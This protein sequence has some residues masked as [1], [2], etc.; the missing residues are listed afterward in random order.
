MK[1]CLPQWDLFNRR[2]PLTKGTDKKER[3]NADI[4]FGQVDRIK[5]LSCL[6]ES[7]VKK[8]IEHTETQDNLNKI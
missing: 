4:F 5:E 3:M 7:A 8:C 6:R 1:T 2:Q